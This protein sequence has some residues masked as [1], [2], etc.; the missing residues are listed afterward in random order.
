MKEYE[1]EAILDRVDRD[2]ATVGAAIPEEIVLDGESVVL[3][4]LVADLST[5]SDLSESDR[6]QVQALVIAL[7]QKRAALVSRIEESIEDRETADRVADRII[8]VNRALSVLAGIDETETIE[9]AMQAQSVADTQRWI[10]F[11]K[12][13]KGGIER[14]LDR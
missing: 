11:V 8:G 10:S 5:Q 3:R 14:G 13:A 2:S 1:R 12:E 4:E 6:E 9:A 7:R